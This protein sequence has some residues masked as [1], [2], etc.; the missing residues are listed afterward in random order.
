[1]GTVAGVTQEILGES[2]RLAEKQMN[3][4][5]KAGA[6]FVITSLMFSPLVF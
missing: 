1:M 3:T 6:W 4:E 5:D 2:C